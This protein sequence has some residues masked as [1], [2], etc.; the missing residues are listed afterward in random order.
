MQRQGGEEEEEVLLTFTLPV[1]EA[2]GLI[3]S[4]SGLGPPGWIKPRGLRDLRVDA[5]VSRVP[6]ITLVYRRVPSKRDSG[7]KRSDSQ[8]SQAGRRETLT[9]NNTRGKVPPV[10]TM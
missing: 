6:L 3:A 8:Q 9:Y 1:P 10:M 2:F 4:R 7:D 5:G